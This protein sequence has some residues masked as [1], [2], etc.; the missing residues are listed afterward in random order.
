MMEKTTPSNL[1]EEVKKKA[2]SLSFDLLGVANPFCSELQRAPE[3]HKPQDYL[4]SVKSV[5][6]L[7]MRV[8]NLALQTTPSGIYSKHYD[9]VNEALNS[10]AYQLVK[11]LENCSYRGMTFPE[12]DSYVILWEQYKAGYIG[13]KPCFNHMAIAVAA[14]LGKLG[15]CG[16]VLTPKYG[17]RQRWIS[18]VTEA[19]LDFCK[20]MKEEMCLEKQTPD[21]CS[22]CIDACPIKAI[23]LDSGTNVRSCWIHWTGLR[24]KGLACGVCIRVCPVGHS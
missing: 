2:E 24:D 17:V 20:E 1:M 19:P 22:K 11:W 8:S 16:V 4:P 13:F 23:S 18:M 7:G 21:S 15:A 5:L 6:A 3:G 14:G 10:G 12:T 9:T